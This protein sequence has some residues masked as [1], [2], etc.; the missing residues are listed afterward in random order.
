[1][2]KIKHNLTNHKL[3]SVYRGMLNRCYRV[4]NDNYKYY[5]GKGVRIS[6]EWLDKENEFMNFYTWAVNNGYEK[7]LKIDRKDNNKDY[8][9]ENCRWV[10]DKEQIRNRS[11][12]CKVLYNGSEISIGEL[13]D[14][15]GIPSSILHR[16]IISSG[17]S[18]EKAVSTKVNH[19]EKTE[20]RTI[21]YNGET[22]P[23]SFWAKV[24]NIPR[25][26]LEHR[27]F[28]HNW[29]IE[30]ALLTPVRPYKNYKKD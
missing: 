16:R 10:T 4:T 11:N 24:Y 2:P 19:K 26:T 12:T 20:K 8:S 1:M 30:S 25:K 18:I 22:K 9:P 3:F 13:S 29:T 6:E 23:I 21:E 15:V 14:M 27:I 28:K 5:G 7:H 17:W